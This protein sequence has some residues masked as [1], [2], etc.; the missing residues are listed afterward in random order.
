[1]AFSTFFKLRNYVSAFTEFTVLVTIF[2]VGNFKL[3]M[4]SKSRFFFSLQKYRA[5]FNLKK[6]LKKTIAITQKI[7]KYC[8][9]TLRIKL[10]VFSN[11]QTFSL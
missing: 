6:K 11:D 4:E 3:Y 1:M 9:R 10:K 2:E 8:F 7:L 5:L